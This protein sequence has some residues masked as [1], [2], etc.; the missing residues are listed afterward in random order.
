MNGKLRLILVVSLGVVLLASGTGATRSSFVDP[1]SSTGNAF[2]A[3]A[4]TS[5]VQTTQGDFE[6]GVLNSVDTSSS[7]GNVRLGTTSASVTDTF[8]DETK[9]ASK[10][11]L[12]VAGGQV[13]LTTTGGG[14]ET[15]RP[16]A[17]GTYSQCDRAGAFFNYQCV[18]EAVADEDATYVYTQ[19]GATELDTYNITNHIQGTGAI[20][21]VTVYIRARATSG[22]HAVEVAI[23][24]YGTN[25]FGSYTSPVSTSYTD[26]SAIWTE[27]PYTNNAWTWAEIDALE[28]GVRHYDLGFGYPLTTQ[29]YVEVDYDDT[30]YYD[31]PGILTSVNLLSGETVDSIDSFDYNASSIPSGTGLK[32]QFSQDSTNWY[33]SAGTASGWDT[34]SQ[35]THSI[36]LSGLGWS[37]ANFYYKMEFTSDGTDTPVLD[38]IS[39]TF[40][41]GNWYDTDWS[42]RREITIDHTKVE[43]VADPS[44]TYADFPVLVYAT[45]LSNIKAAGADIRFTSSDGTTELP[46]EI[47]DYS[48]GTLYAWVKVTLTKDSS[49]ADDDVIY[50]Y[51]GNA[52]ATE[53]APDSAYGSQNV[54]DDNYN[55]VWHLSEDPSGTAPQMKD[56]TSNNNDGSSQGSMT[57]GNQVTGQIDGSL[58]FDGSNHYIQTTSSELKTAAA[59][60][61]SVWFKADVTTGAHHI[62]W[63]GKGTENGWGAGATGHHEMH[64]NVGAYDQD[65]ILGCFY[66][67]NEDAAAP[68]VIR[69]DTAFSDT[70][71]FHYAVFVV[72]NPDSSPAGELFLDGVSKGTDT[73]DQTGRADWDTNL[74]IGRPGAD[75][76]YFDG[77]VDEVR[78]SNT[79]RSAD[80]IETCYNNQNSPSAFCSVG[81]E[82]QI[83]TYTSL[84]SIASQVLDTGADG[85]R[86]DALFWDETL[87]GNTDITF[88]AR[89]SNTSF[90]KDAASPPWIPVGGDSPVISG[91]PSGRYMQWQAT[92]TTSDPSQTPTLHEVRVYYSDY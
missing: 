39:V 22:T 2:Q 42:Y 52:A 41:G 91:L 61:I 31:S 50:M 73:G 71:N 18:D 67:T 4:S 87:L 69:I 1:G 75:Q 8:D 45:G 43:D 88:K 36:D 13:K 86:W 90:A 54:W 64:I 7:P 85:A 32:V 57:A 46:R 10:T 16:N 20:N 21:S 59:I 55:G 74:R 78:I 79:A 15:L 48:G 82:Q 37:G 14:T 35:G 92:L 12:V 68:N 80:W 28:A 60:T 63:E 30:T 84:G 5:W 70:A 44:T 6:A 33:N 58:D 81:S 76:R 49:D 65:N 9:I 26:I 25:D 34:L 11:N 17:T 23:R 83:I 53:P 27:N 24:T 56:S 38:E 89:A 3:W 40:T 29:V 62:V 19:F 47:E 66:G 77:M 51:Y 72:T